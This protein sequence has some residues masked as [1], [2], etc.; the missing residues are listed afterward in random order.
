MK[1]SIIGPVAIVTLSSC[2]KPLDERTIDVLV[3]G[4]NML[5][6]EGTF[7]TNLG[8]PIDSEYLTPSEIARVGKVIQ[9]KTDCQLYVY[10]DIVEEDQEYV[11]Q[12]K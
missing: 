6:N 10:L 9:E 5:S 12:K 11:V 4:C 1:T 3:D 2:Q 7:I 8:L